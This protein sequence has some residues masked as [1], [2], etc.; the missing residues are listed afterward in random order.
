M[1]CPAGIVRGTIYGS[2]KALI[3]YGLGR[4]G[5]FAVVHAAS[6]IAFI[7]VA[8]NRDEQHRSHRQQR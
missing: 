4:I 2:A 5:L 7:S 3:D 8:D 1:C 6:V